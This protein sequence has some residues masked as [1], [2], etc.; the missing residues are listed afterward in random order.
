MVDFERTM[1]GFDVLVNGQLFGRLMNGIGFFTDATVV[2]G[3]LEVSSRDLQ[4]IALKA[5]EIK[6]IKRDGIMGGRN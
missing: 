2:R 6:R 1:G 3:H 4:T 5:D